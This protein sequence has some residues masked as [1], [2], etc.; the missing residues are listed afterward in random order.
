MHP[1]RE[2]SILETH[3]LIQFCRQQKGAVA[4]FDDVDYPVARKPFAVTGGKCSEANTVKA[5][6]SIKCREPDIAGLALHYAADGVDRKSISCCPG[7][8]NE[9][10]CRAGRARHWAAL[11][12]REENREDCNSG[13]KAPL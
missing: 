10:G 1:R 9:S 2:L 3:R 7:F 5:H 8:K 11:L 6:E 4:G 12:R 13:Q